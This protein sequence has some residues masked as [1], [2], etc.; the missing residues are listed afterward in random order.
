M[1]TDNSV[2]DTGQSLN[3][4]LIDHAD[5]PCEWCGGHHGWNCPYIKAVTLNPDGSSLINFITIDGHKSPVPP[6][7]G[8]GDAHAD[9]ASRLAMR[10]VIL[11]RGMTVVHL[12]IVTPDGEEILFTRAPD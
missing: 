7:S 2:S 9:F 8:E 10:C 5:E 6:I 1:S 12:C 11:D 3:D 4:Q